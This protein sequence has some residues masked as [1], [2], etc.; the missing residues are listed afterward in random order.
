MFTYTFNSFGYLIFSFTYIFNSFRYLIFVLTRLTYILNSFSY[1]IFTMIF[2]RNTS[3]HKKL[4]QRTSLGAYKIFL[5]FFSFS[6]F[7]TR[8]IFLRKHYSNEK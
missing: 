6:F 8:S 5:L 2:R 4:I 3:F 1:L 7:T